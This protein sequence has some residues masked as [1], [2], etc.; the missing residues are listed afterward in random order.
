MRYK[1]GVDPDEGGGVEELGRVREKRNHN[2]NIL[3][4]NFKFNKRKKHSM[5]AH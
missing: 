2:Q 3:Y 5:L 1:K 4:G